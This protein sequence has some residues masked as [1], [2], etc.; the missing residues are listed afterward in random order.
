MITKD[1]LS[2][3]T[4]P[5]RQNRVYKKNGNIGFNTKNVNNI[6]DASALIND[7]ANYDNIY[8]KND[9]D[10]TMIGTSIPSL[11]FQYSDLIFNPSTVAVSEYQKMVDSQPILSVAMTML[12]NLV[13]NQVDEFQHGNEEYTKFIRNMFKNMNRTFDSLLSDMLTC[14][15]MGFYIGE[16][17]YVSDGRYIYVKDIEPRPAQ[18]I[19]FRVDSQGHLKEDGI[20]QYYFNS[21]WAGNGNL[22]ANDGYNPYGAYGANPYASL[23]DA[24]YPIRSTYAQMVGTVI[25]PKSKCVHLAYKGI[26][27]MDNPYGKSLLRAGY[28]SYLVRTEM[29]KIN[30][31]AAN[32]KGS[33]IPVVIVQPNQAPS[34]GRNGSHNH[35]GYSQRHYDKHARQDSVMDD[36]DYSLSTLGNSPEDNPY[37]LLQG[38]LNKS[39]W[40]DKIDS[41]ADLR[42]LVE[43]T[44]YFDSQM[45]LTCLFQGDLMGLSDKGS[46][47]LGESQQDLV[48]RNVTTIANMMNDCLIQQI[49]KPILQAN[50][51]EQDDF[52]SFQ[53]V[54]DVSE[55][56]ALNLDKIAACQANGIKL[57]GT[58]IVKMMDI[59]EDA[60]ESFDAPIVDNSQDENNINQNFRRASNE[61]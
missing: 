12:F 50:F 20:V 36:I 33:P 16:K 40:L 17:K 23:G 58:A 38:E 14:L 30:R 19:L 7:F 53:N 45:L 47:A 39:I 26:N 46:Y 28:D 55:D 25:I 32:F 1:N 5:A 21:T 51:N 54:D 11:Y 13:K 57:K 22:Y 52:G 8:P 60:V 3:F 15:Q 48:G 4:K 6:S 59:E 27:G 9:A 34:T 31:N 35:G 10:N 18:S 44:K 41:T 42:A 37:L 56:I 24:P 29:T 2:K 61:S 43:M 49:V